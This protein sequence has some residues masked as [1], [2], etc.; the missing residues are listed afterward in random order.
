MKNTVAEILERMIEEMAE[1]G[2]FEA[3]LHCRLVLSQLD[4]MSDRA[5]YMA[6]WAIR[7]AI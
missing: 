6:V 5:A 7:E 2:F 4:A 1:L 3:V